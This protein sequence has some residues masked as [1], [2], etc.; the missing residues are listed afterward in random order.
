[1]KWYRIAAQRGLAGAQ[2]FLANMYYLGHGVQR[3]YAD[4]AKWYMRSANNGLANA[5]FK[6]GVLYARGQGVPLDLSSAYFW[7]EVAKDNPN[8]NG[9]IQSDA[10]NNLS[11]IASQLKD[12]QIKRLKARAALWGKSHPY[13]DCPECR[14]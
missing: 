7:T 2:L 12:E 10:T 11:M 1:M 8:G 14:L 13:N 5:E 6:L 9:Q 4:A 3:N